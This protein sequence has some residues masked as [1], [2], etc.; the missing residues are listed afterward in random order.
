MWLINCLW[1]VIAGNIDWYAFI[2][3]EYG[4]SM[5]V[6]EFHI[7]I[8]KQTKLNWSEVSIAFTYIS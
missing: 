2:L 1:L 5:N 8:S 7:K 6:W 3:S 4:V